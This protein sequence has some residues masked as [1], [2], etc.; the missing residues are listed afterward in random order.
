[1]FG[2]SPSAIGTIQKVFSNYPEVES[3][4]LFGS[5]AKGNY[6][7]GS[8]IDLALTGPPELTQRLFMLKN[9][10]DESGL[11]YTVDLV[12]LPEVKHA[13]L[14]EHIQRVGKPIYRRN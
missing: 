10:F 4:M 3:A 5:R 2:L 1:M 12:Y 11:P 7:E 6:R 9:D 14:L 13:E 8:D